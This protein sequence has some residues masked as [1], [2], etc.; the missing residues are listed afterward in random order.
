MQL[1]YLKVVDP[2]TFVPVDD[3]VQGKATVIIAARVGNTRLID[4]ENIFLAGAGK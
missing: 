3:G 4:N 1:D 2:K